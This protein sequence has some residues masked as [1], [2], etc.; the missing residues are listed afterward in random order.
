VD[1]CDVCFAAEARAAA[2]PQ[3]TDVSGD[4]EGEESELTV[5]PC[6]SLAAAAAMLVL[7]GGYWTAPENQH[8]IDPRQSARR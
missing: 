4:P 5:L 8:P 2:A 6:N 1:A 7:L 3:S